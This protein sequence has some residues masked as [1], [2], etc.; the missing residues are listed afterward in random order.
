LGVNRNWGA[1]LSQDEERTLI[2]LAQNGDELA[3]ERLAKKFQALILSVKKG[4]P[5]GS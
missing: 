3:K 4:A 2:R 5:Q 1:D